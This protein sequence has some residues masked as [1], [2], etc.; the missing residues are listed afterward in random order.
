MT[1]YRL[2]DG[3]SGRP[4]RGPDVTSYSGSFLAGLVFQVTEN[5]CYFEG[6]WWWVPTGGDTEPQKFALWQLTNTDAG[7]IIPGATVTSG[8]LAEG[9]WNYTP[10]DSPIGLTP[11]IA[12]VAATGWTVVHGFPNTVDQFGAG[13]PYSTGITNGPVQAYSDT[14][15]SNPTP[16]KWSAQGAFG[17]A[18][19][20]PEIA[21]PDRG[22]NSAN[23]WVDVQ[24]SDAVPAGASYRLWPGMP[25]PLGTIQDSA[26]NFTLGTEFRLSQD[27]TL[28]NIWFY[29]PPATSQLPT[30]CGIWQVSSQALVSGTDNSAPS[31]SGAAGS[32]WVS[33]SYTGVILPAGDYKVTVAN[34]S[35]IPQT[36][37]LATINY[38]STGPGSSGITTGPLSAPNLAGAAS[39]GQATYHAGTSFAWPGTYDTGGAPS[40]WVDVEV[41]PVAT[42]GGQAVSSQFLMFFP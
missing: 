4:G 39:P 33:C 13:Q 34:A 35:S 5:G 41:T 20:D 24:V 26:A 9:Q 30:A 10:L 19:P 25:V 6:F 32:G 31:W 15:A 12:Y 14:G 29:T 23:F 37:N 38:W 27:C 3:V 8:D 42:S 1:A 2:M 21:M 7:T 11:Q 22:S 28:N 18:S 40:Y 17:I 16:N 36:W